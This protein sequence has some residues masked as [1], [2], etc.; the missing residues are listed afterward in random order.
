MWDNM[1]KNNILDLEKV[2][3]K[4]CKIFKHYKEI[5]KAYLFGSYARNEAKETSD[6]DFFFILENNEVKTYKKAIRCFS[7]L[8][9][10]FGKQIDIV[11]SYDIDEFM[12]NVIKK[13][14]I[15]I[16]ER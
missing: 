13:G 3:N 8:E 9:L 11:T 5:K 15:L 14:L 7:D 10:E 16:Y 6:I 1:K 4:A 12:K 2:R